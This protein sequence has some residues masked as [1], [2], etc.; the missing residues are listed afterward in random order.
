MHGLCSLRGQTSI[1][2][3]T[4]CGR[5]GQWR[6]AHKYLGGTASTPLGGS[7]AE[8]IVLG[9]AREYFYAAPSL[10]APEVAQ[11]PLFPAPLPKPFRIPHADVLSKVVHSASWPM[12]SMLADSSNQCY[13]GTYGGA[14][15]P[16]YCTAHMSR[17][18][19][20]WLAGLDAYEDTR[21]WMCVRLA[22]TGWDLS[23][24]CV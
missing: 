14:L 1:I 23:V 18:G 13:A 12:G 8:A 17:I 21:R 16:D 20:Q 2:F 19:G 11:V 3:I 22:L 10:Q 15:E 4:Y 7:R 9:C 24:P 5:C 6:L